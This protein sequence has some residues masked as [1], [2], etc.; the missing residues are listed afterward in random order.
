MVALELVYSLEATAA[1]PP[2]IYLKEKLLSVMTTN[3]ESAK[4]SNMEVF[5]FGGIWNKNPLIQLLLFPLI[6]SS[7]PNYLHKK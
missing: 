1:V 3:S 2:Q 5:S 4:V 6:K 7:S